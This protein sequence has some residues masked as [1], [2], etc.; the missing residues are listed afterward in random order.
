MPGR[1]S[2]CESKLQGKAE[3]NREWFCGVQQSQPPEQVTPLLGT[4]TEFGDLMFGFLGFGIVWSL[5][6][7]APYSSLLVVVDYSAPF[8]TVC[9][10]R[11]WLLFFPFT[12]ANSGV[13]F[14][15]EGEFEFL[16][17]NQATTSET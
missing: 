11:A 2:N 7:S 1:L 16:L 17:L 13:V 8:I 14:N 3:L 10:G 4:H 6:H 12:W 15:L 5:F 9:I